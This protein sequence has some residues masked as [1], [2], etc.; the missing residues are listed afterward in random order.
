[1]LYFALITKLFI[2]DYI[3][4]ES[5]EWH[6]AKFWLNSINI[7]QNYHSMSLRHYCLNILGSYLA[8]RL[9]SDW[10][11]R[12]RQL[13]RQR[14]AAVVQAKRRFRTG[15]GKWPPDLESGARSWWRRR[16]SLPGLT[17]YPFFVTH[18]F[19]GTSFGWMGVYSIGEDLLPV[20]LPSSLH[21]TQSTVLS[22]AAM[23]WV[24][25]FTLDVH[26]KCR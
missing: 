3:N 25:V 7:L 12:R 5:D 24:R 14:R 10:R 4:W 20:R 17:I 19:R 8:P 23:Q 11:L 9:G 18:L 26:K 15:T 1:M 13:R 22:S 16:P 2:I 6:S 21:R